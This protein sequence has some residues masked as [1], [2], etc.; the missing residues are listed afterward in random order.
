MKYSKELHDKL[1]NREF[2]EFAWDAY[3]LKKHSKFE[4]EVVDCLLD[5]IDRL[6][7]QV[8]DY[9]AVNAELVEKYE[10]LRSERRWI[11]VSERLPEIGFTGLCQ[12]AGNGYVI[13]RYAPYDSEGGWTSDEIGYCFVTHWMPLPSSPESED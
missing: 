10:R 9:L 13:A 1:R 5:E 8:T 6:H 12:V 2:E 4:S 11:P 7:N 3:G